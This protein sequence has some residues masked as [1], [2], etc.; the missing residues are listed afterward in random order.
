MTVLISK[1]QNM[2]LS[3]RRT[4]TTNVPI[5]AIGLTARSLEV[6][7]FGTVRLVSMVVL[8]VVRLLSSVQSGRKVVGFD[9]VLLGKMSRPLALKVDSTE[10]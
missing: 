4:N 1:D 9:V 10:R 8:N 3:A 2:A 7:I 5:S 6:S